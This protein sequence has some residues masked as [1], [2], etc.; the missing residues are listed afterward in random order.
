MKGKK[1]KPDKTRGKEGRKVKEYKAR[2]VN[3]MLEGGGRGGG[4][5]V[6]GSGRK[7]AKDGGKG[8]GGGNDAKKG[9]GKK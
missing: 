9:E 1:V 6:R 4:V 7:A 2:K 3:G 8:E 5:K